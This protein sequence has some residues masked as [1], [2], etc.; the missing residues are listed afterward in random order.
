[1]VNRIIRDD[2][3][4]GDMHNRQALS[5]SLFSEALKDYDMWPIYLIGLTWSIPEIPSNSYITLIIESLG[6][7]TFQTNLLTVPGYLLFIIQVPLWTWVSEKLN[8]RFAVVLVSQIWCLPI[9]IALEV[10]PGGQAHTWARY[11]L[12][13]MLVG[14]PYIHPILGE[15]LPGFYEG[16]FCEKGWTG[17]IVVI[18]QWL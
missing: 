17:L 2:P 14:F 11:A 10:L 12:N 8:N 18:L 9:L 1:M 13:I 16:Y 5:P 15:W 7:D 3:S 4:K 6:F